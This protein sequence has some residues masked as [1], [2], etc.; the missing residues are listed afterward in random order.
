MDGKID[1]VREALEIARND[2]H[3]L[4]SSRDGDFDEEGLRNFGSICER[5][6]EEALAALSAID[7]E[8]IRRGCAE[9]FTMEWHNAFPSLDATPPE[10][11]IAAIL[12]AEP[13]EPSDV[14]GEVWDIVFPHIQD[15]DKNEIYDEI[16]KRFPA[17]NQADPAQ[18]DGKP[19]VGESSDGFVEP[20]SRDMQ[21][22]D[23]ARR[24]T[25]GIG[26]AI[27]IAKYRIELERRLEEAKE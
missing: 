10:W 5:Q 12:S 6:M 20:N 27:V 9:R 24:C 21:I 15:A 23:E 17:R 11:A 7:P 19:E 22:A 8:A 26:A 2:F 18:D 14:A 1:T 16:R 25:L 3:T 4:A 13:A